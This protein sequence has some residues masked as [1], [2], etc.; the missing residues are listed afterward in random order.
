MTTEE[1]IKMK[2]AEHGLSVDFHS[3]IEGGSVVQYRFEPSVGLK[4]TRIEAFA[5]D[6]EQVVETAGIRVLAPIPN[7]GLVGF[8]VPKK[9]RTFP[10][11]KP[12]PRGFEIPLGVDVMG[13]PVFIDLR[14]APHVLIAGATGSG[15]S[16]CMSS[17]IESVAKLPGVEIHLID[18]KMVELAPFRSDAAFYSEDLDKI[19][20]HF[21]SLAADMDHRYKVLQKAG[22]RNIRELPEGH[23][24]RYRFV[25]VDEFADLVMQARHKR[26]SAGRKSVVTEKRVRGAKVTIRETNGEDASLE[27]LIARIAQKGR[28]AGV[29][30]IMAT[31]RPSVNVITGTIKANFPT[32]IALQTATSTDSLVILD[33]EGAESL[34]GKG[35]MLVMS[36]GLR[37]LTRLQGY[38]L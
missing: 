28:A 13:E 5:K 34:L 17:I 10:A 7:T 24:M 18:P 11:G 14:D 23:P 1:K 25:F 37:G 6:I 4:M 26:Q 35:D 2:L 20:Q 29:H 9:D 22:V 15:K 33:D 8:E 36:P 16:V 12:T 38:S 3:K 27:D 21:E 19:K 32:R 31:Q 30:L